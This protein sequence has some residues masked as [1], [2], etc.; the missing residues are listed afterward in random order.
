M[1][2][3]IKKQLEILELENILTKIKALLGGLNSKTERTTKESANERTIECIQSE[4]QRENGL[5]GGVG[6]ALWLC[7]TTAKDLTFVT[8]I[9]RREEQS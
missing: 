1:K 2:E 9:S 4:Q 6:K 5:C 3:D 7:G 8:G